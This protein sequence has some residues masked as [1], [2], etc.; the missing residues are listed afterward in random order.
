LT[1]PFAGAAISSTNFFIFLNSSTY[2]RRASFVFSR[3]NWYL[4]A[5]ERACSTDWRVR[6]TVDNN[7]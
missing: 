5:V 1:S 4:S 3:I 6:S 2:A 7:I